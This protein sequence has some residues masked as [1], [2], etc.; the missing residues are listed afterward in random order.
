M[1]P[2][3]SLVSCEPLPRVAG[4]LAGMRWRM[5]IFSGPMRTSLTSS[6]RTRWRSSV[7]AGAGGG[8]AGAGGGGEGAAVV[9]GGGGVRAVGGGGG[10]GPA[11]GGGG[12]GGGAP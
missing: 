10:G 11:G 5:V 4:S 2:S 8:G 9:A 3:V 6:R 7:P 1:S 12:G